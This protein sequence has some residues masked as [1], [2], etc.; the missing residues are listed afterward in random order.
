[1]SAPPPASAMPGSP[2][3]ELQ[4]VAKVYGTGAAA[5]EAGDAKNGI[6]MN[7]YAELYPLHCE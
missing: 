3:I 4:G 5:M 6:A 2:L 7:A 1:M